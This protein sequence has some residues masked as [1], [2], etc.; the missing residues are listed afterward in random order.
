[1]QGFRGATRKGFV[2]RAR[3]HDGGAS[4]FDAAMTL[5][6]RRV[7]NPPNPWASR[8]VEWLDEPPP[9]QLEV[10]EEQA[11]SMLSTNDSPDLPFRYS[12]NPYR[13]CQHACAYCYAR[14]THQYLELGAGS[15]FDSK[16]VVKLNAAQV[17]RRELGGSRWR[18]GRGWIAF[19]GVTDCYQPLEA[20]YEITR[21]CLEACDEFR[22]P[23]G[24]ITKSALVRRD[25]ALLARMASRGGAHVTV[26]IP[27]A[28]ESDSRAIEPWASSPATRF[29]TLRRLSEAGVPT[30][31]AIAPLIPGLNDSAVAEILTRARE[32]GATRAFMMLLRL[33]A[34]VAPVFEERLRASH[35]LRAEK[36]LSALREMRGGVLYDASFGRRMSGAGPRWTAVEQ[37]FELQCRRL[38]YEAHVERLEPLRPN[39]TPRATQRGLFDE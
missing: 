22:H 20:S 34:E 5:A 6:P 7:T 33:P 17:L 3:R 21:A 1:V 37:L 23:V 12:L 38:G 24:V 11:R 10:F 36:V 39:P 26:S 19:S 2:E 32:A 15:D 9:V 4:S 13:G 25:T 18:A 14:P 29:D 31:V 30:G 27:F 8:H 35:P 16:I 28:D